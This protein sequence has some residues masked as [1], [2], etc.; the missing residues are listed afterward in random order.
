[1]FH[2]PA[3]FL[4]GE[5]EELDLNLELDRESEAQH[6]QGRLLQTTSSRCWNLT[7]F[8]ALLEMQYGSL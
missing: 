5:I 1:M 7:C 6:I 3:E 8:F 2:M 4:D